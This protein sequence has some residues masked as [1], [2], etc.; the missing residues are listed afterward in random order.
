MTKNRNPSFIIMKREI[1]AYFTSPIAYIVT[2]LFMLASGFLFFNTFFLNNRAELR[3]YFQILPIILAFFIPALTMRMIADEK[4]TGSIE[5][6]MTLPLTAFDITLGKFL[7]AFVCGVSMLVPTLFYVLTCIKFGTPDFGPIIGGYLGAIFLIASFSS[8][9][10]FAT[11]LTKNQIIAFFIAFAICIAF[12][13]LSMFMIFIPAPIVKF[14]AYFSA[15]AHFE[16][17]SRGIIDSRD[18]IYFVSLTA[19]F[20]VLSVESLKSTAA[21]R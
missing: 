11:S 9:G 5:T 4:R 14:V 20:F 17:I 12:A 16:S 2:G 1:L 10:L 8:I 13:L 18:L 3:N 15:M 6:L 19:I 21:N 7:A